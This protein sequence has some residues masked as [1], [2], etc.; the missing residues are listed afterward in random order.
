MLNDELGG[1][2]ICASRGGEAPAN[3]RAERDPR[4]VAPARLAITS[5]SV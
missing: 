1:M 3:I 4:V 2:G 5:S